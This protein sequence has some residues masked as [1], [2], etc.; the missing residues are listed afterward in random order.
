MRNEPDVNLAAGPLT[1]DKQQAAAA[2]NVPTD[3][4]S[5]LTRTGQLAS[6]MVGKHKR[7]LLDDLREYVQTQRGE[8]ACARKA[9]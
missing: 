3:T 5:N 7:W 1:L 9:G 6:I 2:L 4:V 8:G